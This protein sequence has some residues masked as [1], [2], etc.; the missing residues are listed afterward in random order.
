VVSFSGTNTYTG[1]TAVEDAEEVLDECDNADSK[2]HTMLAAS[3]LIGTKIGA[4]TT[5]TSLAELDAYLDA[6]SPLSGDAAEELG[7][8][9]Q[10][11]WDVYCDGKSSSSN[12]FC[13]ALED[14]GAD[15]GLSSEE[16]GAALSN[17]LKDPN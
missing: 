7:D 15:D 6:N 17:L 2:G 11:A 10:S 5:G 3:T 16:L 14:A 4:L 13:Q 8:A 1:N 12:E 9:A